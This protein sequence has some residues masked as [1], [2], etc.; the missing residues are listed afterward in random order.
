MDFIVRSNIHVYFTDILLGYYL[1]RMA[2]MTYNG[3]FLDDDDLDS[4]HEFDG[5]L[6]TIRLEAF[7]ELY[8]VYVKFGGLEGVIL[9]TSSKSYAEYE[10]DHWRYLIEGIEVQVVAVPGQRVNQSG[11]ASR[12]SSF[13]RNWRMEGI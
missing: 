11:N 7:D 2:W 1:R 6:R 3:P 12:L 8:E 9:T 5:K 13:S 4:R 10:A